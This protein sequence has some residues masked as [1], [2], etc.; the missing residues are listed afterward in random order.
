[1]D[2]SSEPLLFQWIIA[3]WQHNAP[4]VIV[5]GFT[6]CRI[7][8]EMDE[9]DD[10]ILWNECEEDGNVSTE[11]EKDEGTDYKMQTVTLICKCR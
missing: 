6:K 2:K 5:K 4:E 1:M 10:D 8:T 11:C 3:A 9:T 7:A